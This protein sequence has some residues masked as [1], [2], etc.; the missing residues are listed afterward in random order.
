MNK[1]AVRSAMLLAVVSLVGVG[2]AEEFPGEQEVTPED[3]AIVVDELRASGVQ[4]ALSVGGTTISILAT[5]VGSAATATACPLSVTVTGATAG[6]GS[7]SLLLC[8]AAAA[9]TGAAGLSTVRAGQDAILNCSRALSGG[10]GTIPANRGV[11]GR[12][13][14]TA[15][16]SAFT[17]RQYEA[18]GI[19]PDAARDLAAAGLCSPQE[20]L[21]RR[22]P[23]HAPNGPCE[24]LNGQRCTRSPTGYDDRLCAVNQALIEGLRACIAARRQRDYCFGGANPHHE[25]T[26]NAELTNRVATCTDAISRTCRRR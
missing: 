1:H 23:V 21:R 11:A 4:C 15:N 8:G 19:A 18:A 5:I 16:V 26:I 12:I 24:R 25:Q 17:A 6:V 22:A 10:G 9:G 3:Q 2:C 7:P 20:Y 13:R 14:S